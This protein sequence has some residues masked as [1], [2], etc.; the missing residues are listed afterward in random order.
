MRFTE[1]ETEVVALIS[2]GLT[3]KEICRKLLISEDTV[4][5]YMTS[6]L[7]KS[8]RRNRTE[9]AVAYVMGDLEPSLH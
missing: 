5:H 7:L 9:I 8:Q 3:N 1:R 6:I 2:R 4:K